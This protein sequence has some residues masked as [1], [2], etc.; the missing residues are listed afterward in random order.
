MVLPAIAIADMT[1]GLQ[2]FGIT[3]FDWLAYTAVG[4]SAVHLGYPEFSIDNATNLDSMVFHPDLRL[5][6]QLSRITLTRVGRALL[7]PLVP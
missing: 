4:A 6:Y 5:Q 3:G 1:R 2:S 7:D